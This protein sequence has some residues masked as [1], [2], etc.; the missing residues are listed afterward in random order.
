MNQRITLMPV[1]DSRNR[2]ARE[3]AH[4]RV[5]WPVN[6][7]PASVSYVSDGHA[8]IVGNERDARFAARSLRNKGLSSVTLLFTAPVSESHDSL[9]EETIDI[10]LADTVDLNSHTLAPSQ[11]QALRIEGYLGRFSV[12]LLQDGVSLNLATALVS[13]DHF[14]L[15][16]DLG[17]T[18]VLPLE[19]PPPGYITSGLDDSDRDATL[20]AFANLVGE[21]DKPRYFQINNDLC[22][23]SNSG[24][25]G[26]TRCLDV[27][28]AD[29][30]T[31]HQG[32]IEA[33]V[34][35]DPF[36]CHGVGSCTSSCP[37]GAIQYRM[38]ETQRQQ[39]T[40][41][42]W[43]D[44]YRQAGGITPV[45][46]FGEAEDMAGEDAAGHV[47]DIPLEEL[48]AAGH[49]Q[50][51]AALAG[52]AAE[53]RIQYHGRMPERLVAFIDDQLAQAH[54]LLEALG[55]SRD[56]VKRIDAGDN[57]ARD[58]LP[59]FPPLTTGTLAFETT[60]K[61]ERLNQVLARLVELGRFDGQ[62]HRMPAGAAYGNIEVNT[63][64]C[65]L[66]MAC[67][68]NCPTPALAAGL[69]SPQLS[70][71]EADCVQCGLCAAACP[72]NAISL[73]PGFLSDKT[74]EQRHVCH[75]EAAFECIRCGK[76][77]ASASAI[78]NIKA[79]LA[80]HPYF[81]GDALSRLEMC[82]DCRVRDVWQELAR[83]PESQLK[84]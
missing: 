58:A 53:V 20:D 65:T 84:V 43:L 23:H 6:L 72:E 16:L 32:R 36:R 5:S 76:P 46:R 78:A 31:S 9:D 7:T 52:G 48:G 67:V 40:L 61:R 69:D 73:A 35:I 13:R 51:L 12:S 83:D 14:D 81:A 29:A 45:V 34:E 4:H 44:A 55:H 62:R 66:C 77:F 75:E 47:L 59:T 21:F 70:F 27:C 18:P 64:A 22:A 79:K 42:A 1:D 33:W 54:T 24:N 39:E 19:L 37:T 3:H 17:E 26:C 30:I 80:D 56:R 8:L 49:D 10:L 2:Q 28:P 57:V 71:R 41:L 15:I 50:W 74:R 11:V 60:G 25:I 38:P 63:A 82:E 68:A